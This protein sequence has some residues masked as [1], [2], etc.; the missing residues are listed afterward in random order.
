MSCVNNISI[1]TPYRKQ[2]NG[3]TAKCYSFN[4]GGKVEKGYIIEGF[5]KF[6]LVANLIKQNFGFIDPFIYERP[7][8][9]S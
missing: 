1:A 6:Y 2:S 4:I 7:N 5:M 3:S 9:L 8:P